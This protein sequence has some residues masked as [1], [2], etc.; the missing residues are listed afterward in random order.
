MNT[1]NKLSNGIMTMTRDHLKTIEPY[2][3]NGTTFYASGAN[4]K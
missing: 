1:C 3:K 2:S 4:N